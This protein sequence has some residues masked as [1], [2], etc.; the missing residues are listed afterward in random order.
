MTPLPINLRLFALVFAA[1]L[2]ACTR[3]KEREPETTRL[4]EKL[5]KFDTLSQTL[6]ERN[7]AM[8]LVADSLVIAAINDRFTAAQ[9]N[10]IL[11]DAEKMD[12][13]RR[14]VEESEEALSKHSAATAALVQEV[15]AAKSRAEPFLARN[16]PARE[17]TPEIEA[18]LK[19]LENHVAMAADAEAAFRAWQMEYAA[20]LEK[21]RLAYP[22]DSAATP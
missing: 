9:Q 20:W 5:A 11:Q 6:L 10:K 16:A 4:V 13:Y 14:W 12:D 22:Q 19:L 3:N 21:L 17:W 1:A 2:T 15:A 7:H 18:V 8:Q